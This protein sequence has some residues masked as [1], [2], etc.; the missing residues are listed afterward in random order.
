MCRELVANFNMFKNFMR[1]VFANIFRKTVTRQS[2]D[3]RASVANLLPRNF[4]EFT[5]RN[6]CE[7]PTNVVRQSRDI[8]AK[9]CEH[10]ETICRENKTKLHSCECRATLSQMS[11][12]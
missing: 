11:R 6:I 5:M 1:F 8:L 9:T 12:D 4:N 10:L 2:H 3:V 7:T